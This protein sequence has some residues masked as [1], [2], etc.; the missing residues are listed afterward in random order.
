MGVLIL[1]VLYGISA[2]GHASQAPVAPLQIGSDL[3]HLSAG[4]VWIAGLALTGW[5]L[6]RLPRVAGASGPRIGT[7]VLTRF[8]TVALVALGVVA[9]TGTIR[10]VGQISDP[11]QLWETD[12]GQSILLKLGLLLLIAPI[13]LRNRR[14]TNT[15][16]MRGTPNRAALLSVRRAVGVEL[17]AALAIVAVAALLVAQV[18]GR[19]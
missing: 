5:C 1:V 17:V 3:V 14:I 7:G 12:Y 13:A 4:A 6:F 16:V 19:V 11:A 18:P 15:L 8:S 2:Q 10:T 9:L